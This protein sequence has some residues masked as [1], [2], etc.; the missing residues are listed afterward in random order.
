[1]KPS[2][3]WLPHVQWTEMQL[4]TL[5]SCRSVS[6]VKFTSTYFNSI[7][8]NLILCCQV[9]YFSLEGWRGELNPNMMW[10]VGGG[11]RRQGRHMYLLPGAASHRLAWLLYGVRTAVEFIYTLVHGSKFPAADHA[12]L[13]K[14]LT[15]ARRRHLL[16]RQLQRRKY[17]F[18]SMYYNITTIT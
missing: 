7:S 5:L 10:Q 13:T 17:R 2:N 1:M 11:E 3:R 12:L 6:T 14:L 8:S 15:V 4:H 9:L 16:Q 18:T